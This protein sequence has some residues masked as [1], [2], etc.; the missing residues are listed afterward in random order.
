MV[1]WVRTLGKVVLSRTNCESKGPGVGK[2][3]VGFQ[4]VQGGTEV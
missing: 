3:P 2:N 4:D 1:G